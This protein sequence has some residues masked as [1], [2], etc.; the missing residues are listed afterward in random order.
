VW[1]R[2]RKEKKERKERK[3]KK[4]DHSDGIPPRSSFPHPQRESHH[5]P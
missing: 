3:E 1:K 4:E 2:K 5:N